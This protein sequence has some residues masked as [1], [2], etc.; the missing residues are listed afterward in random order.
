MIPS[1]MRLYSRKLSENLK[2]KKRATVIQQKMWFF[3]LSPDSHNI[4]CFE[5]LLSIIIHH[6]G[7]SLI[8]IVFILK[9]FLLSLVI[10]NHYW[11]A[12][13]FYFSSSFFLG[14]IQD[15]R[16]YVEKDKLIEDA[17][18]DWWV[19]SLQRHYQLF[20]LLY[21]SFIVFK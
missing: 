10:L 12:F 5:V 18:K 7:I 11:L 16:E 3:T 19:L 9:C 13:Y 8:K 2:K 17:V 6:W 1:E 20:L 15:V 4:L 14:N 21:Q